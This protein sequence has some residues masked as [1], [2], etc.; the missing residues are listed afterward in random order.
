MSI[1]LCLGG[2]RIEGHQK[3]RRVHV[4]RI[5]LIAVLVVVDKAVTIII[6]AK[7]AYYAP[8]KPLRRGY[9]S[10]V[11]DGWRVDWIFGKRKGRTG[12]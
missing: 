3:L 8:L 5:I 10:V 11:V 6:T 2:T 12:A 1:F 7:A 4:C 9:E